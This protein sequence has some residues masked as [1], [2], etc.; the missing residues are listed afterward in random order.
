[1]NRLLFIFLLVFPKGGFKIGDLPITWGYLLLACW[2]IYSLYKPLSIERNH[3]KS[4]LS[5]FPFQILSTAHLLINGT[6]SIDYTIALLT[7]FIFIPLIMFAFLPVCDLNVFLKLIKNSV[8]PLSLY[9]IVLFVYQIFT[10]NF[11]EIPLITTNIND[12]GQLINKCNLRV[13]GISKLVSTYN[14]GNI[15]GLCL[16]MI[17]PLY[18]FVEKNKW[19][20][21][22]VKLSLLLTL[23]RTVWIGIFIHEILNAIFLQKNSKMLLI[24]LGI[25]ASIILALLIYTGL[26]SNFIWDHTLGGRVEQ[27]DV[28]TELPLLSTRPFEGIAEISYLGILSSFGLIGLLTYLFG[29]LTPLWISLSNR[30]QV[31]TAIRCGLINY[32]IISCSDGAVLLIP[33]MAVFWLLASVALSEQLGAQKWIEDTGYSSTQQT[34][35]R[36][37]KGDKLTLSHPK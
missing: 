19:K 9:G 15:Y 6:E 20:Q 25:P 26:D 32:L 8:L 14:N 33:V 34:S 21:G 13:D 1:M 22:I 27:L 28:L 12:Y 7:N 17:L 31:F 2:T 3:F 10:G 5:L 37:S 23:S 30:N 18:C 16:L 29:L 36:Y 4:L 24:K 11:F 35:S